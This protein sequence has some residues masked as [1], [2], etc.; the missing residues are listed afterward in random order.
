MKYFVKLRC[1]ENVYVNFAI[2]HLLNE[3][4]KYQYVFI[5]GFSVLHFKD[6]LCFTRTVQYER[7]HNLKP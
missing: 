4:R 3:T 1:I 7:T 5:I 6:Y 2:S